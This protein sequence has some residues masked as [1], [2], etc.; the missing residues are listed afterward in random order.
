MEE[1]TLKQLAIAP[2]QVGDGVFFQGRGCEACGNIGYAGRLPIFEF[3]AVDADIAE[4]IISNQS[5][6]DIRAAARQKGHGGLLESGT[7]A[8][9]R[10]LTTAEEVLRVA[11]TVQ[12]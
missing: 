4:R 8:V 5:E 10:G 9:L 12:S 11:S 6:S 2:E 1:Q 3:L 7:H